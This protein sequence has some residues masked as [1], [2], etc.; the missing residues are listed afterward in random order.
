[1]LEN[2]EFTTAVIACVTGLGGL[3]TAI[4]AWVQSKTEMTTLRDERE[5]TKVIRDQDSL[6]MHDDIEKLKFRVQANKDSIGLLFEKSNDA[7][8]AISQLN[9]QL[10][11]VLERLDTVIDTLKEIKGKKGRKGS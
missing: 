10:A 9:T 1:M 2:P 7:A 4:T 11:V 3:I 8:Q 6:K 5:Q